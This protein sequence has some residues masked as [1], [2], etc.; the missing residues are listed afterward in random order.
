[1][2][3]GACFMHKFTNTKKKTDKVHAARAR[4]KNRVSN[5]VSQNLKEEDLDLNISTYEK[6]GEN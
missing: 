6:E 3:V 1:M 2:K 4:G 5:R